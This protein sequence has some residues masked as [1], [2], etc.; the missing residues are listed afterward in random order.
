MITNDAE[1]LLGID[2]KT[3]TTRYRYLRSAKILSTFKHQDYTIQIITDNG[4]IE[5]TPEHPWLTKRGIWLNAGSL[6][7]G[8][9]LHFLSQPTLSPKETEDYMH[10]YIAGVIQGDGCIKHYNYDGRRRI[11]DRQN[12]FRLAVKDNEILQTTRRFLS[13]F[14]VFCEI[15]KVHCGSIKTGLETREKAKVERISELTNSMGMTTDFIKGYLAGIF[16]AE[17]TYTTN[18]TLRIYN[19]NKTILDRIVVC[20]NSLSFKSQVEPESIRLIGGMSEIIRF[21][22]TTYPRVTRKKTAILNSAKKTTTATITALRRLNDKKLTYNLQTSTSTFFAGGFASHN[23]YAAKITKRFPKIFP[24]GF[25]PTFHL[26]RLKEP[27]TLKK[28][29]RIFVCSIAD[30]FASW[31]PY[32]WRNAVLDAIYECPIKHTFILLTKNPENIPKGYVF[33]DNVWVGTTVTME[34]GDWKNIEEIKTINAK[35]KFVS[36]EPLLGL[37]PDNVALKGLQWVIIGKLTGSKKVKLDSYWV[38]RILGETKR[39]AIPVFMK[40]NLCP[41]WPKHELIQQFPTFSVN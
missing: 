2:E 15:K 22:A 31:T 25:K 28:P 26:E 3:N 30:L 4:T 14:G 9:K 39:H 33:P 7:I 27:Y 29:S 6:K 34:N 5:S 19:R 38:T 32:E 1:N 20:L 10:G 18:L 35:V 37:L 17:G 8:H 24:N 41:D 40:K 36:F 12:I 16:D 23:C 11:L 21:F 13:A